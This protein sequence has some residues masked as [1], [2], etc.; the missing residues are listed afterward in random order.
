MDSYFSVAAFVVSLNFLIVHVL[1]FESEINTFLFSMSFEICAPL[2]I[3]KYWVKIYT[4]NRSMYIVHM[5]LDDLSFKNW[6]NIRQK[7]VDNYRIVESKAMK[8]FDN[9]CVLTFESKNEKWKT[10]I[11]NTRKDS[12]NI[13]FLVFSRVFSSAPENYF[14]LFFH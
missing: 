14:S 5:C 1:V 4:N 7:L 10:K 12:R 11:E 8:F 9:F 6:N 3:T 2:A 13:L